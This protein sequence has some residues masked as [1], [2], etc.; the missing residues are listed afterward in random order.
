MLANQV[1]KINQ[2]RSRWLAA[3]LG[4]ILIAIG[5]WRINL[6]TP[7]Q[8]APLPLGT[9]LNDQLHFGD[10]NIDQVLY[11]LPLLIAGGFLLALALRGIPLVPPIKNKFAQTPLKL[12]NLLPFW[13]WFA[14]GTAIFIFLLARLGSPNFTSIEVPLW[15]VSLFLFTVPIAIWDQRRQ[16][17]LSPHITRR[18]LLWIV[19]LVIAGIVIGAYRLQGLPDQLLGDDGN[20]WIVARNIAANSFHPSIFSA[21][22]Y[23][24]PIFSSYIQAWSLE[25]FGITLWSW[26]FGSV[27]TG[28]ATI[29]PLYLLVRD[30]FNRKIAIATSVVLISNPY[31]I[32]FSRLGYNNIQAL[33][34]TT[35]SLYWMYIGLFRK[36]SF[37]LYLAGCIAGLGFYTFFAARVTILIAL[38]FVILIWLGKKINFRDAAHALVMLCVGFLLVAVPYILYN[39]RFAPQDL[40]YKTFESAFFNSFNGLQF[41][42]EQELYSVA[43]PI[44]FNGNQLFFNPEIYLVL[45]TRGFL[46]TML[47]FQ[48]SGLI[49]EHYIAFPLAGMVGAVFYLIGFAIV[50]RAIKQP[51]NLLVALWFFTTVFGLSAL[52]TVPP[53]QTHMVTIIPA[54]ALIIA[55]GICAIANA[56][57][58]LYSKVKNYAIGILIVALAITFAGGLYD[59]FVRVPIEYHPQ[60]DQVMTWAELESHGESFFFIY[61][62]PSQPDRYRP[63]SQIFDQFVSYEAISLEK[64]TSGEMI[65]SSKP[66]VIFYFPELDEQVSAALQKQGSS[67]TAR[68]FYSTDGTPVLMARL[69]TPFTFEEDKTLATVLQDSYVLPPL[70]KLLAVM[71]IIFALIAFIPPAIRG[72]LPSALERP[73]HWFSAP[74]QSETDAIDEKSSIST[75]QESDLVESTN[76][77]TD[78][79]NKFGF[80]FPS[81]EIPDSILLISGVTLAIT[82]Q[83]MIFSQ[84]IIL[85][86]LA[87]LTSAVG[88]FMW[89][90]ENPKWRDSISK[91]LSFSSRMEALIFGAILLL[92][93][94]VSFLDL[95]QRVYGLEAD[96]T[97]WTAQSW[98][99]TI[100]NVDAG[101]F[102]TMHYKY[103]PVDFWVRSL[104]L[105][106]FG[107]NFISARIESA[108]LGLISVALLYLLV[109]LLTSSS[110]VALLSALLFSLSFM[111]L[112][113]SHQALHS[114]P[115]GAWMLAAF[116]CIFV[117]MRD[118][119]LWQFQLTGILLGLGMLTYET[120]YPNSAIAVIYLLGWGVYEVI[121]KKDTARNWLLRLGLIAW[122]IIVVYF[123]STR[124]YMAGRE[125]YLMGAFHNAIHS[126]EDL[127][128]L[129][130]Y[131]LGNVRDVLL[132]TFSQLTQHDSLLYWSGPLLN[133]LLLPFVALGIIYNIWNIRRPHYL[134]ILLWYLLSTISGPVFLGSVLPR[135]MY[136][137]LPVLVTWG[138]L[139]LWTA[140]AALR[141]LFSAQ[142]F[143]YAA[144]IFGLVIVAILWN[145][146]HIFSTKL[147]DPPDRQKR[148]ELADLTFSAAQ[149]TSMILF[150]YIPNQN[151]SLEVE[152]QV[153]IFSVAGA[154]HLGLDAVEHYKQ[155]DF[156]SVLPTLWD[157][158]NIGGL[159]V[160]YD[161]TADSDQDEQA[162]ALQVLLKCYPRASLQMQG[163]F[164]DVYHFDA[165]ALKTP[166]C[167][168]AEAPTIVTPKDSSAIP[169]GQPVTLKWDTNGVTASSFEVGLERKLDNIYW[170][171]AENFQ[172]DG[173]Y[174]QSQ[175]VSGFSGTGFLMD[176]WQAGQADYTFDVPTA[177]QYKVWV[178]FYKRRD[179]DQHNFIS[180]NGQ[181]V[182]FA[183][184]GGTLNEWIWK[185]IGTFDLKAGPLPLAL[186]R[187]Y[188]QDDQY[189]VF[190]DSIVLTSNPTYQPSNEDSEWQSV[191]S[192]GEINSSVSEYTVPEALLPGEYRWQVRVFDG[193]HLV[194]YNGERGIESETSHFTIR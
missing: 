186:T 28:V 54:L 68:T 145:D 192:T 167:Y 130:N 185:D 57:S 85:G 187:T 119:K 176:N 174:E 140:F 194:D 132:S 142:R 156:N 30:L 120:F 23:T 74:E 76:L 26:R 122:P 73:V 38:L 159:D 59:Y 150:P 8:A 123:A 99:S 108:V 173:W 58:A 90:R 61:S 60:P 111:E 188:G 97:K 41:Y 152:S 87:Y 158:R 56:A 48:K 138:A 164:F 77:V 70:D 107:L 96:E 183:E 103:L 66:T 106:I 93:I 146:Y 18:D 7:P 114:T 110:S 112:N 50:L 52:N 175:F 115:P 191:Q 117:A 153:L 105:R 88:L 182:E 81:L 121:K 127:I 137:T 40:S 171:E 155:I 151:D 62:D 148:R 3:M 86:A 24:F 178:R 177:G 168:S 33:F 92:T 169:A 157:M 109:R 165:D 4:I 31:F 11:G 129:L 91:Q 49:T 139:G 17:D 160:F 9:W 51:R 34:F 143:R 63:Y 43:P 100:L 154:R 45:I 180:V 80:H 95:N 20:F 72:K 10:P 118:R 36:S 12:K 84:L 166:A 79:N 69:N 162:K 133:P 161:K 42:S 193:N 144:A 19:G 53:R 35:L 83:M 113:A 32:D 136:L 147:L 22:V 135:V 181:K 82:A 190:I 141:A 170:I 101:E 149:T 27:L 128:A 179:N 2:P 125:P 16:V 65:F 6:L 189:S 184:N 163:R 13:P 44:Q 15:L 98:Y 37:Y 1:S 94:C 29:L 131:L 78:E 67:F 102:A 39:S 172:G 64:V 46:R 5:Q 116:F 89:V 71:L 134:F 14:I 75:E 124:A 25:F 47:A 21:G 55:L 104:F 126:R